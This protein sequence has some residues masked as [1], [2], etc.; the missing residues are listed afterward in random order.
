[1]FDIREIAKLSR[2]PAR[3]SG[4]APTKKASGPI[5]NGFWSGNDSNGPVFSGIS[6][7]VSL[8]GIGRR[9]NAVPSGS[10]AMPDAPVASLR[11]QAATATR[12]PIGA[13]VP[14]V[15][16]GLDE[17]S[18]WRQDYRGDG[19]S[20]IGGR[21]ADILRG[22]DRSDLL[23]GGVANDKL[24]GGAGDDRLYG[25]LGGDYLE[26]GAGNDLLE[27]GEGNDSLHGGEGD[28]SLDG[29]TGHDRL[30][31]RNGDD[32]MAGGTGHD[33]L[34]AGQGNDTLDGGIGE[35]RLFG[36]IGNDILHGGADNDMLEGG[37]G[38]DVLDGGTGSDS[39]SGG[40]GHDL[41]TGGAGADT[42][43]GGKGN[44]T[45]IFDKGFGQDVIDN[46]DAAGR[47]QVVFAQ[48]SGADA[49][50]LWFSRKGDDLEVTALDSNTLEGALAHPG[51]SRTAQETRVPDKLTFS[52]WYG[53][54]DARVDSFR[55]A[56]G[57]TLKASQV[58][59]LVNAMAAFGAAPAGTESLT[60]Q[61]WK[62][63]EPVI[64]AN[65]A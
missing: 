39:L 6:G 2:V 40:D 4:A 21:G 26:G 48:A 65:W 9:R 14:V 17:R 42:L 59:N 60:Q 34:D 8:S 7:Q 43:A 3:T 24:Y 49:Q 31:G 20:H 29:G 12:A 23:D 44:D 15:L 55:D 33:L 56:A 1:M 51:N 28:D 64:A 50:H 13:N 62:Q 5:F 16:D 54:A 32:F 53:S 35:D 27:G 38:N 36:G 41:L 37:R 11:L 19:V 46:G 61:Q 10:A 18:R 47:D 30:Y 58:D 22:T 45:Y 52:N 63:L 57:Q 25:G